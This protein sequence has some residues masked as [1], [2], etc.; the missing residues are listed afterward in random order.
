[1]RGVFPPAFGKRANCAII[2]P[3]MRKAAQQMIS[4]GVRAAESALESGAL[5]RLLVVAG[6]RNRRVLELADSARRIGIPVESVSE[7]GLSRLTDDARH[8][9]IGA[10]IAP[11]AADW[12]ELLQKCE[13]DD[14]ALFVALDGVTDPRNLGAVL[15]TARAFGADGVFAPR[16]RCAPL[17]PVARKAAAGAAEV[18]PYVRVGNLAR[19]L[20]DLRE[21]NIFIVGAAEDGDAD[22]HELAAAGAGAG[23]SGGE[24]GREGGR[25]WCWVLGGEGG[26]LRRLTRE[27]C[28]AMGR[29]PTVSGPA[30]CLNVS[31]ACGACLTAHAGRRRAFRQKS[32]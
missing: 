20:E 23:G 22:I 11:A 10:E 9:G 24:A 32:E 26:G 8:Q 5:R 15:R 25:G 12:G 6:T 2:A 19:A 3:T 1:M 18:L 14:G 17:S 21:R 30:G 28:D 29:I 4:P 16:S 31:V 13:A 7:S 27:K